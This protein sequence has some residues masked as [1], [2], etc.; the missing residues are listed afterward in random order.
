LNFSANYYFILWLI[1]AHLRRYKACYREMAGITGSEVN[2][3][4]DLTMEHITG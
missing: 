4:T 2:R 3:I 1:I